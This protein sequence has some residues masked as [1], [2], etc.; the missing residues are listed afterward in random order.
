MPLSTVLASISWRGPGNRWPLIGL[1]VTDVSSGDRPILEGYISAAYVSPIAAGIM[2]QAANSGIIRIGTSGSL[3][4]GTYSGYYDTPGSY[5]GLN[6]SAIDKLHYFNKT[7]TFVKEKPAVTVAHEFVHFVLKAQ[8]ADPAYSESGMNGAS[9][10]FDSPIIEKQ[11]EI[12][13]QLNEWNNLQVS[14]FSSIMQGDARFNSLTVGHSYTDNELVDVVRLGDMNGPASDNI[15]HT[16]RTTKL[17]D[18]LF[19]FS[20]DDT[21]RAGKGDDYV[22]GGVGEDKLYG[23]DGHDLLIGEGDDDE[24]WGE[25]GNDVI[26]GGTKD[27]DQGVSDGADTVSYA[28]LGAGITIAFSGDGGVATVSVI[29]GQGGIDTL[30]SIEKIL[31]TSHTDYL[32]LD[33][34][35]PAGLS[36]EI[37]MA[38]GRDVIANAEEMSGRIVVDIDDN[39]DGTASTPDG[40]GTIQLRNA[41][42]QIIGS[43]YDDEITDLAEH[44]GTKRIDGG[45]GDDEITVDGSKAT[46]LGGGGDDT[47][48]GGEDNDRLTGGAGDDVID[49]GDGNDLIMGDVL[50]APYEGANVLNGGGGA[51]HIVSTAGSDQIDGGDGADWIDIYFSSLSGFSA[52][53]GEGNDVI[54]ITRVPLTYVNIVL[55]ADGG[56][57]MVLRTPV[58]LNERGPNIVLEGISDSDI[59]IIWDATLNSTGSGTFGDAVVIVESTGASIFIPSVAGWVHFEDGVAD[60]ATQNTLSSFLING[61]RFYQYDDEE[62]TVELG[63]VSSY[64]TAVGDHAAATAGDSGGDPGTGGDDDLDGSHGDDALSG[65]DGD[66]AFNASAGND[67]I[68]GGSGADVLNLFGALDDYL[69]SRD[70]NEI[71]SV[72]DNRGLEGSMTLT[73]VEA[74]YFAAENETFGMAELFGYHGTSGNDTFAAGRLDNEM[75]GLA[76]DDILSGGAGDDL[77]E[78]GGDD[79][80]LSGE[81]GN[82]TL[83]GGDGADI[84]SGGAGYDTSSGGLGDDT[85]AYASGDGDDHV[86]D[87]GGF[88]ILSFGAGLLAADLRAEISGDDYV[89]WF[90]GETGSVTILGGLLAA[91][92]I[93]ELHFEDETMWTAQDLYDLAYVPPILGTAGD[94]PALV[95]DWRDDDIQGLGGNDV[96]TG[97]GGDD[98]IDGGDGTDTAHYAG[99]A[100]DFLIYWHEGSLTVADYEAEGW[101]RLVGVEFLSFGGDAVTIDVG[102]VPLGTSGNDMLAGS[103]R[104]DI[105]YALDGDDE[106][107]G[108]GGSDAL[109][110]GLGND[111]YLLGAGDDEAAEDG[112]DDSYA[113]D[114]GDGNDS[115][116]EYSGFDTLTFGA[117]IDPADIIVTGDGDSYILSFDGA[118]GSVTIWDGALEDYAIE[119]VRFA[120]LTMWT[121]ADL[122]DMAFGEM[123]LLGFA[124]AGYRFAPPADAFAL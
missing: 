73:G 13:V 44:E 57:D 69:L 58:G 108:G 109:Y 7:G 4:P 12:S 3:E 5:L 101:D 37:D 82:D 15:D 33:G 55:S 119:E 102:D 2:D 59:T 29:D 79:D 114:P 10:D 88:D 71:V 52:Y 93:E 51:D 117:G 86:A 96:I 68:D 122:Y 39:G 110:G 112:G 97:G 9:Y 99:A 116:W 42:T 1:P 63:D 105:V 81:D 16:L 30:H 100:A 14:Y 120:D 92:E 124:P 65:G 18:L 85:Y 98:L 121:D 28:G 62:I 83:D 87:E 113:Y 41:K 84:L 66:D 8:Y 123:L 76:G 56:N 53:G 21:I 24:F 89:L 115:I 17:N 38:D 40:G 6:V 78:G 74:I 95:G 43:A 46:L 103:A 26:W 67:S 70:E 27:N 47:L 19:G 90:E 61:S 23:G 45:D 64:A 31:A 72:E 80:S 32:R 104:D 91:S 106:L 49:G 54:D 60:P 50:L 11:N 22:Y 25:Q 94:D 35:I 48:T 77:I 118:A 107:D 36:L 111:L 20:G 75:Y 34:E